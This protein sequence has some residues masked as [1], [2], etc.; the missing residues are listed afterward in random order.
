MT[1]ISSER[2]PQVS[3]WGCRM[4]TT[5][6]DGREFTDEYVYVKGHPANPFDEADFVAKFRQC[7][8]YSILPLDERTIDAMIA[9]VLALEKSSDV[10]ETLLRPLMPAEA[11]A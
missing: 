4:T 7:V 6:R 2:D 9:D 11:S 8:P 3:D 5:L 1:R 10:V